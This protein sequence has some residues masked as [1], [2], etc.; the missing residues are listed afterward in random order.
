MCSVF[1]SACSTRFYYLFDRC[2]YAWAA[3]SFCNIC[4]RSQ[5][6]ARE[7]RQYAAAVC[8]A[9]LR[10]QLVER[11]AEMAMSGVGCVVEVT[12]LARGFAEVAI[13]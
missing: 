7:S 5:L 11:T 4:R 2:D 3:T 6:E 12:R 13:A 10:T 1:V 8:E 9:Q